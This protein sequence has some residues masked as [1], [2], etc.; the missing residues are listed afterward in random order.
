[1]SFSFCQYVSDDGNTYQRKC[2]TALA[3]VLGLTTETI[4]AHTR[5]PS[6]IKP[7]YVLMRTSGGGERKAVGVGA[8]D[9]L[10]V[11]GTTSLTWIAERG[12]ATGVTVNRAGAVGEKRYRK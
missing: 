12:S 7:R 10:F 8:A 11:G 5:L 4:G 6:N 9:A 1:M 3:D 2:D